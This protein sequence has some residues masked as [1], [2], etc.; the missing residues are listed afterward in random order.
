[1]ADGQTVVC[2]LNVAYP[3]FEFTTD[4]HKMQLEADSPRLDLSV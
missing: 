2:S 3:K 1:M 4:D